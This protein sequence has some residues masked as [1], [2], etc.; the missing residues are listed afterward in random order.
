[1][2]SC[3]STVLYYTFDKESE[4]ERWTARLKCDT[5]SSRRLKG[6]DEVAH[7]VHLGALVEL[8][9]DP[10]NWIVEQVERFHEELAVESKALAGV[11]EVGAA[12]CQHPRYFMRH[13]CS[14]RR[15]SRHN[16]H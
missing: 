5:K 4:R 10:D 7:H 15:T 8:R 1:M 13:C 6:F 11:D 16:W 9:L 2:Y 3:S 12:F 14:R